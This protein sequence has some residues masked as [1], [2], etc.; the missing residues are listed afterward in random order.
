MTDIHNKKTRSENMRA[1]KT[2]NTLIE[3]RVSQLL[4]D[5][6]LEFHTQDK[7][8]KGKPDF[9]I[10]KYNA[11][12]FT[13]VC[14]WHLHNCYLFKI[15]QTRTEFWLKKINDNQQRD[16]QNISLLTQQ[17]WKILVIW[18]CALKGKYKLTDLFLKERIEEWLCSHNHNAEID[19]KGL[20]KF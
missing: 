9:V 8:L 2:E 11:I 6:G 5:L 19:I 15:P 1:V 3:K 14:F 10:K 12:I 13:H 16:H 17:G 7:F 20:R 18:G 4:N